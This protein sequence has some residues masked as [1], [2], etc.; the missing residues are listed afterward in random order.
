MSRPARYSVSA[1][2]S[3]VR[4]EG[5]G[6]AELRRQVVGDGQDDVHG[7]QEPIRAGVATV[8]DRA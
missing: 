7:G 4:R 5:V 6:G 3:S 2:A 1:S 8:R